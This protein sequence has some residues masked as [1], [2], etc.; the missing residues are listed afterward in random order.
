MLGLAVKISVLLSACWSGWQAGSAAADHCQAVCAVAR[1]PGPGHNALDAM[2]FPLRQVNHECCRRRRMWRRL[3]LQR[4]RRQHHRSVLESRRTTA[5]RR[6]QSVRA[7]RLHH[8]G[9][10]LEAGA[11]ARADALLCCHAAQHTA[12]SGRCLRAVLTDVGNGQE[13]PSAPRLGSQAP[14]NATGPL[15]SASGAGPVRS[16]PA[17]E[18]ASPEAQTT[19][20]GRIAPQVQQQGARREERRAA[21]DSAW[22]GESEDFRPWG[23]VRLPAQA[24][25]PD[26]CHSCAPLI[27]SRESSVC[28]VR[29]ALADSRSPEPL[30]AAGT[31][32][33]VHE[34]RR[35]RRREGLY[36]LVW[37]AVARRRAIIQSGV[38]Y[39]AAVQRWA[40]STPPAYSSCT[41]RWPTTMAP[42][43]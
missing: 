40:H 43:A 30:P 42:R 4:R 11:G 37:C 41:L 28:L 3:R 33:S 2:L 12:R 18:S 1:Q 26:S 25:V 38:L 31:V 29:S 7:L 36:H 35:R 15:A 32:R 22:G 24:C 16:V 17:S 19:V 23:N 14:A 9:Q 34:P 27:F 13:R 8:V 21:E 20:P 39:R 5:L 6:I 10:T